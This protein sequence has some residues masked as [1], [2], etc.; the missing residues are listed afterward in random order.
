MTPDMVVRL[1]ADPR[2]MRVLAAVALGAQTP[3][4]VART[5]NMSQREVMAAMRR[6]QE[7][8]IVYSD[9]DGVRPAYEKL[10][11][12]SKASIGD[13]AGTDGDVPTAVRSF[14]RDGR[15]VS[16]PAQ[17]ARRRTLLE[18][19]ANTSFSAGVTYDEREVDDKLKAWCEGSPVDHVSIRRYMI[20]A[21]V[22]VRANGL[23]ARDAESPPPQDS[24]HP[25]AVPDAAC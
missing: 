6:L 16:M 17:Q 23:Y 19:L 7:G 20:E 25:R 14:V 4:E 3:V 11:G 21:K 24:S 18:Y 10:R 12:L 22:L 13:S 5:T 1:I 8:G 15:L 2:R 9:A